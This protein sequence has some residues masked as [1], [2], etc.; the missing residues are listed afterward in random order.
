M[1]DSVNFQADLPNE[2][3]SDEDFDKDHDK[4]HDKDYSKDCDKYS[5]NKIVYTKPTTV[6]TT[7]DTLPLVTSQTMHK[8]IDDFTPHYTMV[9][10][11]RSYKP[12]ITICRNIE[13]TVPQMA[14]LFVCA[15]ILEYFVLLIITRH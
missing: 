14:L 11:N 3:N 9:L 5:E 12:V 2:N 6:E 1:G 13:L 15:I 4:N 10:H 8:S 7:K